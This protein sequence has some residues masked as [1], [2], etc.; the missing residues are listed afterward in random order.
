MDIIKN[1]IKIILHKEKH[2]TE[3]KT[4]PPSNLKILER[5][6]MKKDNKLLNSSFNDLP[7]EMIHNVLINVSRTGSILKYAVINNRLRTI[8]SNLMSIKIV[9]EAVMSIKI[10]Q[11]AELRKGG[12]LGVGA[13]GTVYN[14][15]WVPEGENVKTWEL[16]KL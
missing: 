8:V 4:K 12:I 6:I 2:K 5:I 13:F 9:Q 14:G 7:N 10:V 1:N 11:E 15:V 16:Q 3:S